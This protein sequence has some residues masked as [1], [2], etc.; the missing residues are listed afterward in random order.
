MQQTLRIHI[1][2]FSLTWW[3]LSS[4]SNSASTH[5]ESSKTNLKCNSHPD[6]ID[7]NFF[8]GQF[9]GDQ[10][11]GCIQKLVVFVHIVLLLT[12]QVDVAVELLPVLN[13]KRKN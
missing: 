12:A 9:N 8:I 11:Q 1:Q 3:K 13:T 5:K 7:D 4:Y 6:Q 10:S 2:L